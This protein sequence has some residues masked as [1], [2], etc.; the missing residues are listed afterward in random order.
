MY[1]RH[2]LLVLIITFFYLRS[3]SSIRHDNDNE[4]MI[5]DFSGIY[6]NPADML[7]SS[8]KHNIDIARLNNTVI[9]TSINF[10]YIPFFHNFKCFMDRLGFKY[11]VF[12]MDMKTHKYISNI[13]IIN[14]QVASILWS[15]KHGNMTVHESSAKFRSSQFHII[16]N[17]KMEAVVCI[18]MNI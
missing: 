13:G 10:A 3:I 6:S 16:S 9:V 14:K 5:R 8:V 7:A 18:Y 2:C 15:G 11:I 12:S 1:N 17:S 4:A